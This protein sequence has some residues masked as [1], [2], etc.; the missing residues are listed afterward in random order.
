MSGIHSTHSCKNKTVAF[1]L[2]KH[3]GTW[4]RGQTCIHF[5]LKLES[6]GH[7]FFVLLPYLDMM[8]HTMCHHAE[9]YTLIDSRIYA[10]T[11]SY[12]GHWLLVSNMQGPYIL[13]SLMQL[14]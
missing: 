6:E 11:L 10:S 1:W 9:F 5:E 12:A 4:N 8:M 3:V 7:D 13:S 14:P 2:L